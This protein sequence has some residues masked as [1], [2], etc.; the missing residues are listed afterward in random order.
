M[1]TV[2]YIPATGTL[3]EGKTMQVAPPYDCPVTLRSAL[4]PTAPYV[5]LGPLLVSGIDTEDSP[6]PQPSK[7][8]GHN[9]HANNVRT[10]VKTH[11]SRASIP[12]EQHLSTATTILKPYHTWYI[13]H[14]LSYVLATFA[15]D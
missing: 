4:P 12:Y 7:T 6:P 3:K 9:D 13:I 8:P 10:D 5:P 2:F 1:A 15:V 11:K 14:K